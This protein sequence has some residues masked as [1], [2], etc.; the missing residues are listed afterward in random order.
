MGFHRLKDLLSLVV[1]LQQVT[2]SQDQRLSRN[3]L[4]HLSQKLLT[5]GALLGRGLLVISEPE[6]LAA[7][8]PVL[9]LLYSPIPA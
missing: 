7:L 2:E 3:H 6:L 5:L 9:I 1:L 8:N 4:L